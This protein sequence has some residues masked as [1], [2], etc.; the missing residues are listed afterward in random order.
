MLTP[1][2]FFRE[3]NTAVTSRG[4]RGTSRTAANA[5][6]FVCCWRESVQFQHADSCRFWGRPASARCLVGWSIG[7]FQRT[8]PH[9]SDWLLFWEHDAAFPSGLRKEI[10][11]LAANPAFQRKYKIESG[12]G[13]KLGRSAF[14]FEPNRHSHAGVHEP[15]L[16]TARP[17]L[18]LPD[19]L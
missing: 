10:A 3:V 17:E 7:S 8:D 12:P 19:S 2:S 5:N 11:S 6:D 14:Q 1:T 4:G 15:P 18:P 13:P 16:D 9:A